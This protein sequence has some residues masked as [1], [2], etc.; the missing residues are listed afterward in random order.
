M[1]ALLDVNVLLALFDSGHQFHGHAR[2]WLE[3]QI[4]QG[5]ASCPITQNGF[6]RIVSQPA[7]PNNVHPAQAIDRLAEAARSPHHQ[8]WPDDV[9]ILD[10]A[11]ADSTRIHGAK[12]LT[13]AYLLALAVR[14]GGCFATFDE[15]VPRNAVRGATREHLRLL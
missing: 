4:E 9:S 1:R 13:D 10:S 8:F 11:V 3:E 14:H 7:Y 12:Q 15:R 5:W 6:I 2:A